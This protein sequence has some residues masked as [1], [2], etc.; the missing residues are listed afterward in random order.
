M[1]YRQS[2]HFLA[3]QLH[4]DGEARHASRG[5]LDHLLVPA[6]AREEAP[7][8]KIIIFGITEGICHI[9]H[10]PNLTY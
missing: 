10:R 6:W 7:E 5:A 8:K 1:S 9:M 2:V 3:P 4:Q